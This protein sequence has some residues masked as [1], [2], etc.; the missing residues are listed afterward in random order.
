MG[1]EKRLEN[2]SARASKKAMEVQKRSENRLKREVKE[3]INLTKDVP[4]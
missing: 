3:K 1:V 4:G 2:R